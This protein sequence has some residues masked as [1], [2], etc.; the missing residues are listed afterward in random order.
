MDFYTLYTRPESGLYG[1]S[2]TLFRALITGDRGACHHSP[3]VVPGVDTDLPTGAR[4][5]PARE[6]RARHERTTRNGGTT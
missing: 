6:L 4:G 1:A 5:N 3:A 2:Q